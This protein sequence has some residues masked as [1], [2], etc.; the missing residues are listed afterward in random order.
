[1]TERRPPWRKSTYSN[2]SSSC[3]ETTTHSGTVAI[4]DSKDPAGPQLAIPVA[5]WL[6]FTSRLQKR[7]L[8]GGSV[9]CG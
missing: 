4:R 6:A 3:I 1:M 5:S 2:G 8:R 7:W 9:G